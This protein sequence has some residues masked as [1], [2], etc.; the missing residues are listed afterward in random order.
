VERGRKIVARAKG[1]SIEGVEKE[2]RKVTIEKEGK[3]RR[4]EERGMG[5]LSRKKEENIEDVMERKGN[6]IRSKGKKI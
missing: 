4:R 1:E 5:K 2:E 3:Y 6:W